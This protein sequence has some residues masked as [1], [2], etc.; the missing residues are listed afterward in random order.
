MNTNGYILA[1]DD[2]AAMLDIYGD[3]FREMGINC[4]TKKSS[5]EAFEHVDGAG[6]IIT[7]MMRP[8][9]NGLEF[10]E[11]VRRRGYEG[12]ILM[13]SARDVPAE[14]RAGIDAVFQKPVAVERL[15]RIA[16]DHLLVG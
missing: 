11:E 1:V 5:E 4:I 14:K 8:G 13:I 2:Y 3:V 9:M 12:S 10:V 7:D 16:L 15:Q 6:L